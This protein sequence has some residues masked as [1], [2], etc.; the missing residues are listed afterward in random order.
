MH[1]LSVMVRLHVQ[2]IHIFFWFV[3]KDKWANLRLGPIL[4]IAFL[5]SILISVFIMFNPEKQFWLLKLHPFKNTNKLLKSV[6]ASD[7]YVYDGHIFRTAFPRNR[8]KKYQISEFFNRIS[9]PFT[10]IFSFSK[11]FHN[12]LKKVVRYQI[13]NISTL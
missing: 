2:A 10:R 4:T 11:I 13:S 1:R 5:R 3:T 9:S 8:S 7:W 6:L 12:L